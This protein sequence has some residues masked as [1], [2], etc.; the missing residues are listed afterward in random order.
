[1][2][3]GEKKSDDPEVDKIQGTSK[4]LVKSH[5][6]ISPRLVSAHEAVRDSHIRLPKDKEFSLPPDAMS[7]YVQAIGHKIKLENMVSEQSV[8]T[9]YDLRTVSVLLLNACRFVQKCVLSNNYI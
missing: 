6:L 7:L 4:V 1:M 8:A 3:K 2:D 9:R 5:V